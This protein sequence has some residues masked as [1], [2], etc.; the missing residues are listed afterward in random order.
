MAAE[1]KLIPI[2]PD[3]ELEHLLDAAVAGSIVLVRGDE[4]FRVIREKTSGL[5]AMDPERV[6]KAFERSVGILKGI[7]AEALKAEIRE[8][9]KQD[10]L[11]RPAE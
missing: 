2:E 1:P 8:Q 4:R 11:G 10:S 7:D 9:R 5:P 3:S 6:R